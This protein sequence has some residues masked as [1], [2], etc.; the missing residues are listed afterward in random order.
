MGE[1]QC[2]CPSM[3]WRGDED[4]EEELETETREG[5]G[6]GDVPPSRDEESW[7]ADSKSLEFSADDIESCSEGRGRRLVSCMRSQAGLSQQ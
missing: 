7:R 1:R 5:M 4:W 2:Q 3:T 6:D